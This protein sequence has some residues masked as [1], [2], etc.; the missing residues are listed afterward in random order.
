MFPSSFRQSQAAVVVVQWKLRALLRAAAT[1]RQNEQPELYGHV[2]PH[3]HA[4]AKLS[5]A[6]AALLVRDCPTRARTL[7]EIELGAHLHDIG[8]YLIPESILF[9]PDALSAEERAIISLH[10]A[11]GAHILA[12]LLGVTDTVYRVVLCHHERWDGEGYPEGLSGARI[13][14]AARLV[15]V[16][17]VYTSL[18]AR[19]AYKPALSRRETLDTMEA[20]AGRELDPNLV[21]AFPKLITSERRHSLTDGEHDIG[22]Q[23]D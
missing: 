10:P 14:F 5:R 6:F 7:D 18:R 9:K 16:C 22:F 13:P 2:H 4:T 1:F 11:Y 23:V 12:G 3:G 19:R 17:D 15:A 21:E 8:K 20:M